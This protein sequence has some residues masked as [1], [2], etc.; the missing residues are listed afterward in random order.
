MLEIKLVSPEPGNEYEDGLA[1]REFTNLRRDLLIQNPM[2]EVI[3][4][5]SVLPR[6]LDLPKNTS[7]IKI[8]IQGH[9]DITLKRGQSIISHPFFGVKIVE[10][11]AELRK[12]TQN[13][14]QDIL[15][16]Q[17]SLLRSVEIYNEA[18][19][20]TI[21]ELQSINQAHFHLGKTIELFKQKAGMH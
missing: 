12:Y 10:D 2:V 15:S 14:R 20:M 7:E 11:D 8:H 21:R 13:C 9:G 1:T 18:T 16:A 3:S 17:R 19:E 6:V 4:F 5:N